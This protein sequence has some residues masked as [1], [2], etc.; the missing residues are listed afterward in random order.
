MPCHYFGTF[1]GMAT[2]HDRNSFDECTQFRKSVFERRDFPR[3]LYGNLERAVLKIALNGFSN[4]TNLLKL[5]NIKS[6]GLT[7]SKTL[8]E[9][10]IC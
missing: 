4:R 2:F 6:R 7:H 1:L 8:L 5:Y 3:L 9:K 10:T